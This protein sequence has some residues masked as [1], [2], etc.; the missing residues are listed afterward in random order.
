MQDGR[1]PLE[2]ALTDGED[3]ELFFAVSPEEGQ[4]VRTASPVPVYQVG[5]F[6]EEGLWLQEAGERRALEA[7]GYVHELR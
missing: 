3:F 6:V 5:V 4:R 1:T 2:H 7:R